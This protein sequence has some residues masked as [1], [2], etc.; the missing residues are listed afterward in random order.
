M[1]PK[2]VTAETFLRD[3]FVEGNA[4]CFDTLKNRIKKGVIPGEIQGTRYYVWVGPSLELMAP[5]EEDALADALF[6]EWEN[7]QKQKQ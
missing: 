6:E 5:P 4:P 3:G 7:E 1:W 2:R